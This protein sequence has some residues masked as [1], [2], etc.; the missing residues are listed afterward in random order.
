MWGQEPSLSDPRPHITVYLSAMR[1]K[2]IINTYNIY[3]PIYDL[4]FG[5]FFQ[6]GRK[7][8]IESMTFI[9]GEKVL[10]IGV[11]SGQSLG[12]YP[13]NIS[14]VGIDISA[15]MLNKASVKIGKEHLKN[16]QLLIMDA[17][18]LEFEDNSFDKIAIMHVYSVVPCPDKMINE[19]MRVCKP[20]GDI[21]ILNQFDADFSFINFLKKILSPL[22][23]II[24]FRPYFP[25][26]EYIVKKKFPVSKVIH[27]N[28]F[29]SRIVHIKNV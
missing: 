20:D 21:F 12:L 5:R 15:K 24:G 16:K 14:V 29:G 1:K 4:V 13:E 23:N 7:K 25:Y 8:T 27:I 11:G 3:A 2:S 28:S 22:E 19:V 6:E 18:V 10:E 17:E 26:Q 9:S